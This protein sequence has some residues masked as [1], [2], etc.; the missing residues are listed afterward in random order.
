MGT[1]SNA[2]EKDSVDTTFLKNSIEHFSK[3]RVA[4]FTSLTELWH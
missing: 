3:L 4:A 1:T 2:T